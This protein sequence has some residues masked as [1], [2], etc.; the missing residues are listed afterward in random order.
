MKSVLIAILKTVVTALL[1]YLLFRK[2]DFPEFAATLK[3][4]RYDVLIFSFC[5]LWIGHSMCVFRWRMLMRP[6]M[7]VA[8]VARLLGIYCIGLFFNLTFPTVVGGDVVKMYYA[9]K[10]SRRFAES[11]AATF[12][13]R[14]T[15]MLAMM[16]IAVTATMIHPVRL[17]GIPVS[18]IIWSAFLA[19]I[20]ANGIIFAPR[21]HRI[22]V[23]FL[24]G[25]RF[26]GLAGR[27]DTISGVFQTIARHRGVLA[28]SLGIS[29]VNQLFVI[30]V[31]WITAIG[32]R[33]GVPFP[34]FL[35]FVP[36]ITLISMIPISLNGMGL[37]EYAFVAL[38]SAIGVD[39]E[40][41]IALGLVSSAII[42]LSAIPGGVVYIFFRSRADLEQ[43]ARLETDLS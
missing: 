6:L 34:Y 14:D 8:S 27:V 22:F 26:N 35:V 23:N 20:V 21:L 13:D 3:H 31:V 33:I 25:L 11:F 2:V 32:L 10:P 19:F 30:A 1:F 12:L 28:M 24:R 29:L 36:V 40:S 5:I 18:L 41:G 15:G 43:M 9:G 42:V 39:R 7:P 38:F 16:L 4:A 17:D 37:R